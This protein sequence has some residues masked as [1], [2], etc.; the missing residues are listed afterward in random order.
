MEQEKREKTRSAKREAGGRAEH[1][2]RVK[3]EVK[4]EE[5]HTILAGC[6]RSYV[7]GHHIADLDSFG[8]AVGVYCAGRQIGK[9]VQIVLDTVTTSLRPFVEL[10]SP[11]N[12]YP[13]D[14]F[15]P[16]ELA[17]E[18]ADVHSALVVVDTSRPSYTA[19][20]E[21]LFRAG[22]IVVFDHHRTGGETI[23]NAALSYIEPYASSACEMIAGMLQYFDNGVRLADTEADVLYGGILLDT[24][25]FVTRTGVRTFEAAAYLLRCGA[26]S[27]R[28]RKLMRNDLAAYKARADAI[29][30]TEV[31]REAYA[32]SICPAD[33]IESP[34]VACAQAANELLNVVGIKASFVLTKYKERIYIS[35]R[36]IDEINVRRVMER[37]GGGGHMDSAGAQLTGC[38]LE[39]AEQTIK[40][41]IDEM[42]AE[43]K[44]TV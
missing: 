40:D 3:A 38:T 24:N 21:L 12:G 10:F 4:A 25:N 14:L 20:P 11:Q 8:A 36:S 32:I 6:D 39:A 27:V 41:T 31:Y 15:V 1:A 13:E 23:E 35:A 28:V 2:P 18:Q 17:V 34:T 9:K 43:E 30:H 7:M 37:L 5:L 29:R 16:R 26:K 33:N 19:C 44:E 22:S 42:L